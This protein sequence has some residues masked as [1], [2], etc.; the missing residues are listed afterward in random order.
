MTFSARSP[1]SIWCHPAVLQAT[2][3]T[4]P[5]LLLWLP[6]AKRLSCTSGLLCRLSTAVSTLCVMLWPF[7]SMYFCQH[8]KGGGHHGHC[9]LH[10]P[11]L[12]P[13]QK[14]LKYSCVTAIQEQSH[15]PSF[16]VIMLRPLFAHSFNREWSPT[17]FICLS[18]P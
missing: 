15:V 10:H 11:P 7:A 12:I 4:T 6:L 13:T 8:P 17:L 16:M 1:I 5:P 9:C 2:L 3:Q 14:W 18:L